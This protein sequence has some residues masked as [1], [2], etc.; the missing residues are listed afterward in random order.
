M[1]DRVLD[2]YRN[3]KAKPPPVASKLQRSGRRDRDRII[4]EQ[5]NVIA[6]MFRRFKNWRR[7]AHA[8]R[9][10][11]NVISVIAPAVIADRLLALGIAGKTD[12]KET[13]CPVFTRPPALAPIVVTTPIGFARR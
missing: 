12:K 7:R 6:C 11:A 4:Y 8:A 3:F 2:P 1:Q 9:D 13:G 10:I 5:R